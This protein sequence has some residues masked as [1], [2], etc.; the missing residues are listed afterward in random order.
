MAA[1]LMK[2]HD[3][4]V[5]CPKDHT[6]QCPQVSQEPGRS[7]GLEWLAWGR[8]ASLPCGAG[9]GMA[10]RWMKRQQLVQIAS[11]QNPQISDGRVS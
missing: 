7:G 8:T 3:P 5:K 9:S 6:A 4:Q 11:S 10:D 1:S 2:I